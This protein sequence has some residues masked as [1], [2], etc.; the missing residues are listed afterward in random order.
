VLTQ[1]VLG[2]FGTAGVAKQDVNKSSITSPSGLRVRDVRLLPMEYLGGGWDVV[3]RGSGACEE[4]EKQHPEA[5][6]CHLFWGTW[7][8]VW[9]YR[10]KLA[11]E[12]CTIAFYSSQKLAELAQNSTSPGG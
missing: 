5:L 12:N 2:F 9:S 6:V 10:P 4:Y 11:Y 7:K 3:G 1:A 8:S